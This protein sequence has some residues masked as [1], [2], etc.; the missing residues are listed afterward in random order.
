VFEDEAYSNFLPLTYTKPI[1][2][3]KCGAYTNAERLISL[4]PSTKI[5]LTCRAYLTAIARK[6]GPKVLVNNA[7]AIDD[8]TLVVNGRVVPVEANLAKLA[9]KG[10]TWVKNGD[11]V[12][13]LLS[14][15][16]VKDLWE[17]ILSGKSSELLRRLREKGLEFKE[18]EGVEVLR[19]PW[20]LLELNPRLLSFDLSRMYGKAEGVIEEKAVVKG[21]RRSLIVEEEAEIEALSLIDVRKGPVFIG[22]GS[23]VQA[24]SRITG[25]AY[26]GR[27]VVIQGAYVREGCVIGDYC[28][29]GG[30]GEVEETIIH[31]YTNKYHYGF[32]GHSYIGEWVNLA[33]GTTNSDLKN[34]YGTVKVKVG[35]RRVDTGLLKVGCFIADHVKTSIGSMIYT[36]VKIGVCSHIH[37][38]VVGDVPSFTIWAQSLGRRPVELSLE[39]AIET[40]RRMCSRRGVTL[41]DEETE[42]LREVFKLTAEERRRA[43]VVAGQFKL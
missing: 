33:A 11:L 13:C 10:V 36:G 3:L 7:E 14:D 30:G 23:V 38:Y 21:D 43:G 17:L 4:A 35:D 20:E 24:G 9:I 8:E 27:N 26:I 16:E 31:G 6:V 1:Y 29:I 15:R 42:M 19:Y 39:S 37:G 40:A 2:G 5:V 22:R 18:A 32:I 34:T 25:P 12:A 41:S 28:R